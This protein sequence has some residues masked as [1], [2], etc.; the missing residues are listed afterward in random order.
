[1]LSKFFKGLLGKKEE[2]KKNPSQPTQENPKHQE[3]KLTIDLDVVRNNR[4]IYLE[5]SYRNQEVAFR[6][7]TEKNRIV[8]GELL[9]RLFK[10]EKGAVSN[11]AVINRMVR[12]HE[13]VSET[14]IT[15]NEAIW[16]F[17]LFGAI[18]HKQENGHYFTNIYREIT[19]IVQVSS[20]SYILTLMS[21]GGIDT[22]KYMRVSLLSPNSS[23]IDDCMSTRTQNAP[24]VLSFI[25]SYSE[26]ENDPAFQLFDEVASRVQRKHKAREKYDEMEQQYVDG[27]FEFK[28]WYYVGYGRF[29]LEQKRYYDA[30]TILERAFNFLK[31]NMDERNTEIMKVYYDICNMLGTCL[32]KMNRDEEAAYYLNHG[33]F[34]VALDQPSPVA[35]NLARLGNP[36]AVNSMDMW[37][38]FVEQKYGNKEKWPEAIKQFSVDVPN[39]L[40]QYK[41]KANKELKS[42][43]VYDDKI[44]I[45]Y[46]LNLFMGIHSNNLI[47][48]MSI[49]DAYNNKFLKK[50]DG[51]DDIFNFQLNS[52]DAI[53][54]VFVLSV[55]YA[56][57][58]INE[59]EDKSNRCINAPVVISTHTIKSAHGSAAMRVDLFR[60]NFV[61]DDDKRA[62]ERIN[63]PLSAT[64]CMGVAEGL[65][66]NASNE[67]LEAALKK[68]VSLD[69]AHERRVLES[70]KLAKWVFECVLNQTKDE[71]G[72]FASK[73]QHLWNLFFDSCYEVG[74]SLMEL[75]KQ[76]M[77]AYFLE[78]ASHGGN[79]Q[80]VQEYI[81]CLSNLKDPQALEV[82][83]DTINRTPQPQPGNNQDSWNYHMA[84]LKRRKAF[85]LI[86]KKRYGEARALLQELLQDPMCKDFAREELNYLNQ[87]EKEQQMR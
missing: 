12:P 39:I 66:F 71:R 47:S 36:Q 22:V 44:T 25:L 49:Y 51:A 64:F 61:Y 45:G 17:D 16:N 15:D 29:L 40:A 26:K 60:S 37:L 23:V 6:R 31:E 81:N 14:E 70:Y 3:A 68:A 28:G 75:G 82:V 13:L 35:L 76:D 46:V 50:I 63:L 78:I 72:V 54:K 30:Y 9:S 11:L 62:F 86:D 21:L 1:M 80:H 7:A 52:F 32:S 56:G 79:A 19:L 53:N 74:F 69:L 67:G 20:K 57:Y 77:A 43:P 48:S 24:I 73:D 42:N 33:I 59:K 8:L 85:I 87:L 18:L 4:F 5:S 65:Q 58:L 34:A 41:A 2:V 55:S 83:E 27:N 84:F 38:G 10:I